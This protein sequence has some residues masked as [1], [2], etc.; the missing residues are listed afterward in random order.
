MTTNNPIREPTDSKHLSYLLKRCSN[1]LSIAS[2][3]IAEN[4]ETMDDMEFLCYV[5]NVSQDVIHSLTKM[6]RNVTKDMDEE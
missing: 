2:D 4:K 5:E 1:K 3:S 6:I